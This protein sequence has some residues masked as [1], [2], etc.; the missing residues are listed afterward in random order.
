MLYLC[1][2]ARQKSDSEVIVEYLHRDLETSEVFKYLSMMENE[3]PWL[4][5]LMDR[6]NSSY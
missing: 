4:I 6:R 2:P 1:H 5:S 3:N